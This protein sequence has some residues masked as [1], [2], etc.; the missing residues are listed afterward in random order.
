MRKFV[1]L[2]SIHPQVSNLDSSQISIILE[3][4]SSS[5]PIDLTQLLL[6]WHLNSIANAICSRWSA[7]TRGAMLRGLQGDIVENRIIR[8]HYGI[9]FNTPWDPD[10]HE[11]AKY[12]RMAEKRKYAKLVLQTYNSLIK[13]P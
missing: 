13:H 7:V 12:R 1:L 10:V 6:K 5:R 11:S 8:Y 3:T 9:V 4:S 2:G